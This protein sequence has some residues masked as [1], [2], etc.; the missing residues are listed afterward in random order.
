MVIPYTT[1]LYVTQKQSKLISMF[2]MLNI[3]RADLAVQESVSLSL[4]LSLM[5]C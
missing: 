1:I 2:I 4:L 3:H 5:M